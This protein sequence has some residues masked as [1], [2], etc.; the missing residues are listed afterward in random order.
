MAVVTKQEI[1][2]YIIQAER[3]N[4]MEVIA[5]KHPQVLRM[6]SAG[7]N[8]GFLLSYFK[9]NRLRASVVLRKA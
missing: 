4:E 8:S 2:T 1:N 7:A 9:K 3:E 5:K 6:R